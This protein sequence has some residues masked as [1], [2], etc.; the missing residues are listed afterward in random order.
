MSAFDTINAFSSAETDHANTSGHD[1]SNLFTLAP[2]ASW[3]TAAVPPG[4]RGPDQ[5]SSVDGI[6]LIL[7]KDGTTGS[8]VDNP[9]AAKFT[10]PTGKWKLEGDALDLGEARDSI[11]PTATCR[12]D[13]S[14]DALG[15]SDG[16][17][18]AGVDL[19]DDDWRSNSDLNSDESI[20][21]PVTEAI[22]LESGQSLN[23]ATSSSPV[24]IYIT[25]DGTIGVRADDGSDWQPTAT[26]TTI[27]IGAGTLGVGQSI[28]KIQPRSATNV[29][30]NLVSARDDIPNN[31]AAQ[32]ADAAPSL[33]ISD[34]SSVSVDGASAAAVTFTSTTGTL[35][36]DDAVAFTGQVS[37]LAGSDA[38]DLADMSYGA[39][40]T[41]TFLGNTTGGT[42]TVTDGTT[43]PTSRSSATTC[44]R[45][46]TVSSDGNGGTDRR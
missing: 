42:L 37:G 7:H 16:S 38:L 13:A 31:A 20:G 27:S 9:P 5:P 32:V 19:A 22:S 46:G 25:S 43:R 15:V 24:Q 30:A 39:N 45:A 3:N 11:S 28:Y 36:L 4:L 6:P 44:R 34:S 40:T 12:D 41:A 33:T 14:V 10:E 18:I 2:A 23:L 17:R 29:A 26:S 35:K 1:V 8:D 21:T